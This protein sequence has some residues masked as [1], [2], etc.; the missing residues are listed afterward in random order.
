MLEPPL[1][2]P[3]PIDWA[4]T[5]AE[6]WLWVRMVAWLSETETLPPAVPDP[7]EPPMATAPLTAPAPPRLAAPVMLVP[8]EPP[9]PPMDWARIPGD[10]ETLALPVWPV[11]IVPLP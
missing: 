1:P 7:P 9:P 5:P 6:Y 4:I 8:P 3:P 11:T 2:P 10:W